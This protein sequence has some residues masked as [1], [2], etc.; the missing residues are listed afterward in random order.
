[1]LEHKVQELRV[2]ARKA[3]KSIVPGPRERRLLGPG[4]TIL[5]SALVVKNDANR[6]QRRKGA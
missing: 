5:L 4:W 1:M 2:W 6:H 3:D